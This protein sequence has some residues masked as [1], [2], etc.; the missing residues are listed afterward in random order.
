MGHLWLIGMMGSGK[1]SVGETLAGRRAVP[2]YDTDALVESAAGMSIPEIF[3]TLGETGFRELEARVV[4][5]VASERPGIVATGGGAVLEPGNVATM[6]SSGTTVLID[7]DV[8]VLAERLGDTDD[9]PLLLG[10]GNRRL[11]E[12][13]AERAAAYRAAADV[14]VDGTGSI[15]AVADEVEDACNRS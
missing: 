11:R 14:V 1:T 12:I 15:E 9:R 13:A 10:E 4:V 8:I 2:F 6:W 3:E 7:V 5:A